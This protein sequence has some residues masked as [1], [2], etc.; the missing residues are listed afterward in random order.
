MFPHVSPLRSPAPALRV[1]RSSTAWWRID[2]ARAQTAAARPSQGALA[3]TDLANLFGRGALLR[4][5]ARGRG[6][7][8]DHR[9]RRGGIYQR[10]RPRGQAR[11]GCCCWVQDKNGYRNL[12]RSCLSPR[13]LA[14]EPPTAEPRANCALRGCRGCGLRGTDRACRADRRAEVGGAAGAPGRRPAAARRRRDGVL[15][16]LFPGRFFY[17]GTATGRT[18][19]RAIEGLHCRGGAAA[20]P[21]SWGFPVVADAPGTVQPRQATFPRAHGGQGSCHRRGLHAGRYAPGRARFLAA[22]V[23]FKSQGAD[24]R[25]VCGRAGRAGQFDRNRQTL[26]T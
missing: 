4:R 2:E 7:Q 16:G 15:A 24:G 17:L 12:C 9:L 21:A 3:L 22:A 20:G 19:D 5:P 26:A 23:T 8:A 6:D 13:R 11:F 1:S 18:P 25:T 14:A 10:R